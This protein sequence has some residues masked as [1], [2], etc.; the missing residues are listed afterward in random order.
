ME[1]LLQRKDAAGRGYGLSKRNKKRLLPFANF[2]RNF[3]RIR[4]EKSARNLVQR[5]EG[6]FA[7]LLAPILAEAAKYIFSKS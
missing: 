6:A 2:I 4:S 5:G 3:S 1:E 7:I